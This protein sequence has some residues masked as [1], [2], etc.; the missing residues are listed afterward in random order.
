MRTEELIY[1]AHDI[2]DDGLGRVVNTASPAQSRV[3]L[4][5]ER[6]VEMYQG[7]LL[8]GRER[9]E[10]RSAIFAEGPNGMLVGS[11]WQAIN[12]SSRQQVYKFVNKIIKRL[13]FYPRLRDGGKEVAQERIGNGEAL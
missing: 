9:I 2:G 7:V 13:V 4:C 5:Q 3:I 10:T 12:R 11:T 6:F 1:R 8:Q